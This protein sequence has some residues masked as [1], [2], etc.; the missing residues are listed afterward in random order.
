MTDFAWMPTDEVVE[1]ANVTRLIRRAGV[2]S[3]GELL[4]RSQAEPEWFWP[5]V[6]ADLGLE[7]SSPWERVV[8][9]ERGPEWARW[10]VG[11][12]LNIAANCVHR[13]AS[14]RGSDVAAVFAGEDSTRTEFT[15]SE[16]SDAVTRL[17]EGLAA[18]G[19]GKGDVVA[20]YLPMSPEVAIASHACAHLGAVQ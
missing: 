14:S 16:L 20:L 10:F 5:L 17:A 18:L 15:F 7:F 3:Y 13:W 11:G 19:V 1:Y 4:E 8:D 6:V 2:K 9:L 12:T